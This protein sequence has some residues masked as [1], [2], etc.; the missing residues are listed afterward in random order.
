LEFDSAH[1]GAVIP[2]PH[3]GLETKLFVP[4]GFSA[5]PQSP[6]SH[7]ASPK[8]Q[9]S[10]GFNY[11]YVCYLSGLLGGLL[12]YLLLEFTVHPAS[13]LE[14]IRSKTCYVML[15]KV[16]R[17]SFILG[18]VGILVVGIAYFVWSFYM[19]ICYGVFPRALIMIPL[20]LVLIPLITTLLLCLALAIEQSAFLLVDI[21]DCSISLVARKNQENS[22]PAKATK[23]E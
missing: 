11:E 20:A 22:Q 1:L 8:E 12:R 23:S 15:R 18:R 6:S 21:A 4:K 19:I 16:I 2:C 10:F 3:C 14:Q 9:P 17:V 13:Q 5:S 7:A